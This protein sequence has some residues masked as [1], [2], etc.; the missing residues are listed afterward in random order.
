MLNHLFFFKC[1]IAFAAVHNANYKTSISRFVKK[2]NF[3]FYRTRNFLN[4][5][6]NANI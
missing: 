3:N 6:L 1:M 2:W 4:G 5:M